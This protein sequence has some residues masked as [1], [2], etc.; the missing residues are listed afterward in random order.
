MMNMLKRQNNKRSNR[1]I[2]NVVV[3]LLFHVLIMNQIF[4]AFVMVLEKVEKW[5]NV[6]HVSLGT[7]TIASSTSQT[8][9]KLFSV[10]CSAKA[11][12]N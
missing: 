9:T 1:K 2:S 8:Q 12:M 10:A 6:K 5:F 7:I 11:F 3:S 4:T